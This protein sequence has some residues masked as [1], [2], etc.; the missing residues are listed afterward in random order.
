MKQY[1]TGQFEL[2][3]C[4]YKLE[5]SS[6][7]IQSNRIGRETESSGAAPQLTFSV[8]F[9]RAPGRLNISP[10]MEVI[11]ISCSEGADSI[12]FSVITDIV[13][14]GLYTSSSSH[15]TEA[16]INPSL[17]VLEGDLIAFCN[18]GQFEEDYILSTIQQKAQEYDYG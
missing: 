13:C 10:S 17:L 8:S 18:G 2:E 4:R 1:L 11:A 9:A 16:K 7:S 12:E 3:R 5:G 6:R 15:V 14:Q